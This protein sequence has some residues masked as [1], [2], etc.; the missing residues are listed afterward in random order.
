MEL[1]HRMNDDNAIRMNEARR[2]KK[3]EMESAEREATVLASVDIQRYPVK[4]LRD[5]NPIPS[6]CPRE[7]LG[8]VQH[9]W[10]LKVGVKDMRVNTLLVLAVYELAT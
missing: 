2:E 7:K 5:V 3:D 10:Q 9:R 4:E 8:P 1:L 6:L